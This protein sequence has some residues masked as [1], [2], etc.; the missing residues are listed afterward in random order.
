MKK[1]YIVGGGISLILF[2]LFASILLT[3]FITPLHK[4]F[5]G[6]QEYSSIDDNITSFL[7]G[8][9]DALPEQ[10]TQNEKDH[11]FDV[12]K[13]LLWT[14]IL[15]IFTFRL[16]YGA[17]KN[18]PFSYRYRLMHNLKQGK[19]PTIYERLAMYIMPFIFLQFI[20]MVSLFT[21]FDDFF[22]VFHTVLFPQGN[23]TFSFQSILIQTYPSSFFFSMSALVFTLFTLLALLF[24]GLFWKKFIKN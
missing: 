16:F 24:I 15:M 7:R 17:Y 12:R 20:G 23:F 5:L 4:P 8:N 2:L 6:S 9:D 13:L 10:L 1:V 19:Q 3:T 18:R 11:L 22:S 14:F 21:R